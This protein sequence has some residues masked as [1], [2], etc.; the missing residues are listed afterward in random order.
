V[1]LAD[2]C[3]PKRL[4]PRPTLLVRSPYPERKQSF[5]AEL[6]A[7]R[8]FNVLTVSSRGSFG[9]GGRLNPFRQEAADGADVIKWLMTQAW[10][11][12]ELVACGA[13]YS[14]YSSWSAAASAGPM[15][16]AM[17]L[18]LI[19]SNARNFIFPNDVFALELFIFWCQLIAAGDRPLFS[20]ALAN[21]RRRRQRKALCQHLPLGEIDRLISSATLPFWQEWLEHEGPHDPW[22][23][24][25][26]HTA[27]VS[28]VS[29]PVH[30]IGGW[31]DFAIS[32]M[33]RDYQALREARRRP[34]LTVGP[35]THFDL[36]SRRKLH[37]LALIVMIRMIQRQVLVHRAVQV[38]KDARSLIIAR[39]K[40]VRTF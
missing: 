28:G 11:N 14:G 5:G 4:G 23:A 34:Y 17:A 24:P 36:E 10:F 6:F 22:W 31:H 13:S 40:R 1:L 16:K 39:M 38:V 8:G 30:L 25:G 35:W 12:N 9:S 3:F 21:I 2:R 19:E 37:R 29:A 33:L 15:L 26:D 27:S 32:G 18:L 7:E 20:N